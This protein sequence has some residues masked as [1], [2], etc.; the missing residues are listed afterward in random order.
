MNWVIELIFCIWIA[1]ALILFLSETK[2][3]HWEP[4]TFVD[5]LESGGLALFW[6]L[7][8]IFSLVCRFHYAIENYRH[9]T[10]NSTKSKRESRS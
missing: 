7:I 2:E 10:R 3:D 5:Y 9:G 8:W 4:A 1:G 6:P